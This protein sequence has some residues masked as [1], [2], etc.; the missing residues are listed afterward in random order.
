MLGFVVVV[1]A[2]VVAVIVAVVVAVAVTVVFVVAYLPACV[3]LWSVAKRYRT[4]V[5]LHRAPL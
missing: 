1:L 4:A 5:P 2:V 3:S